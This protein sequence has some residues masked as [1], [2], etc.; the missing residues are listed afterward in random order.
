MSAVEQSASEIMEKFLHLPIEWR[1][2]VLVQLQQTFDEPKIPLGEWLEKATAFR[3]ELRAKYGENHYFGT[4]E[5]LDELRDE[6]PYPYN[7]LDEQSKN[8]DDIQTD[9]ARD[10]TS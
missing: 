6:L 1:R 10:E 3:A 8:V 5:I 7:L 2:R 4:Q 9:E